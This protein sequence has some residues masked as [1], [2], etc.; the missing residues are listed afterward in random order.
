MNCENAKLYYYDYFEEAESAPQEVRKHLEQCSV[1]Q[2]EMERLRGILDQKEPFRKPYRPKYL[3]LHYELLDKWISC[4]KVKPFLPLLLTPEMTIKHQ[5]PVTAHIE[6]CPACQKDLKAISSLKLTGL[7]LM[8]AADYLA[9]V[10]AS[11]AEFD[12][13]I[14]ATL[15]DINDRDVSSVM[16]RM[17]L[18]HTDG[19]EQKWLSD[20]YVVEVEYR[21]ARPALER[22][23]SRRRPVPVWVKSGIAAA[24]VFAALLMIPTEDAGALDLSQIYT[25]LGNVQNVHIRMFG[26]SDLEN[27]QNVHVRMLD[28]SESKE[29]QNIW[30]AEGLGIRL[31]QSEDSVV[32][33]DQHSKQV[34]RKNQ[35]GVELIS[36]GSEME[37]ER[38]WGLLPF[39]H[40]SELPASHDWEHISDTVLEGDQ[41]VQVY[42]LTWQVTRKN[43]SVIERKWRG[44]LDVRTHLPYRIEWLDKIDDSPCHMT[45]VMQ[46]SYPTDTECQKVIESYGFQRISY[47]DQN[48]LLETFPAASKSGATNEGLMLSTWPSTNTA[49]N[50]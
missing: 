37:L 24:I 49:L 34:F 43:H 30:I 25:N 19:V 32:F 1:C 10:Q 17:R 33:W 48:E 8:K 26:D 7:E 11:E 13:Q 41:K 4:D 42:E 40:I 45:M 38:P 21:Q 18:E 12:R 27:V 23:I 16:T 44:Y 36:Q 14:L 6:K 47:G 35:G 3:Q 15:N 22:R 46:V 31:I 28:Q 50:F 39:K 29:F 9:A 20:S 5:T 2:E